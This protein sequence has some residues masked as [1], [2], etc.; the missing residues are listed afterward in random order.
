MRLLIEKVKSWL[1]PLWWYTL[2]LF[3]VQRL[4]DV[5][6]AVV[7]LWIVPKFVRQEELGAVLPLTQVGT[8]LGLP[9]AILLLPFTKF[10]NTYATRGEFGKVKRL[11]RDVFTLA[12]VLFVGTLLFA[13][14]FMPLVF[15]RMRIADG[16]LSLLVVGSGVIGTLTPVFVNALQA[17]KEFRTIAICN[18][19]AAPVRL[20]TMLICMPIRAL[21]GYI[22]GQTAPSVFLILASL[23]KLRKRLG[24]QVKAEGYWLADWRAMARY[25]FPVAGFLA[26]GTLQSMIESFVIRH[27][28]PALDSAGFYMISRFAEIGAYTGM[29]IIFVLF[30]LAAEKHERGEKSDRLLWEAVCGSLAAGLALAAVFHFTGERLLGA[31]EI[32]RCYIPYAGSLVTLTV[33]HALRTAINCF[34]TYEMACGRFGYVSYVVF[35]TGL[36]CVLIYGLTGYSF[37][38]GWLP[39]AWI[40]Q[41]A[42]LRAARLSF[43]LQVMLWSSLATCACMF[44]QMAL[45]GRFRRVSG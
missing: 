16:S 12:A 25:T 40:N 20:L 1:G 36:E 19:L 35:L 38:E 37:F 39:A 5:V 30:P 4:G 21:S 6:N 24:R 11:L 10:L 32:W 17:L 42:S 34:S 3:C 13:R 9:L 26:A 23:F 15:E 28:L 33:I 44:L 22:V 27:R 14:F 31:L 18:F 43:L 45:R 2:I 41:M 8:F 7:G 29:T